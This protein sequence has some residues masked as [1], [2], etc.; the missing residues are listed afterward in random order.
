VWLKMGLLSE[1]LL[2]IGK[3]WENDDHDHFHN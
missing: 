3:I 2:W 1:M